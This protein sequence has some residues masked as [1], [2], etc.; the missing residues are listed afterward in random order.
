MRYALIGFAILMLG[1]IA[2]SQD[3]TASQYCDPVCLQFR[4]GAQDCTYHNYAQCLASRSGVGGD[5][6]PNPFLS[7]CARPS[8]GP[9]AYRRRHH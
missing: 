5:C 4:G 2:R 8:A 6:V 7:Q 3:Y 1:G 9:K